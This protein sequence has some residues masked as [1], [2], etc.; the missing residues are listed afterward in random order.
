MS[1]LF[2]D[3]P[4]G[5]TELALAYNPES[6]RHVV[7]GYE[8]HCGDGIDVMIGCRWVEGRYEATWSDCGE[9]DATFYGWDEDGSDDDEGREIVMPLFVGD[10]C[11]RPL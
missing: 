3:S 1:P 2:R 11:R 5:L 7:E 8:L 10:I 9:P 6:R 4:D